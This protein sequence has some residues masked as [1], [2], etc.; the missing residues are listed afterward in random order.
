MKMSKKKVLFLFHE[1]DKNNGANH[2][3]MDI[4][5]FLNTSEEIVPYIAFPKKHGTEVDY[6]KNNN[7]KTYTFRYGRWDYPRKKQTIFYFIK[8]LIK[9]S[10]TFIAFF[11]YSY[12]IRKEK[13]NIVY[14]NTYTVFLGCLL[15][16]FNNI[17]HVWHIREFGEE[18][19]DLKIMFNKNKLYKYM[20]LYSD[21]I[22]FIS[23]SLKQKYIGYITN[24]EKCIVL[25][26]DINCKNNTVFDDNKW[27][28][29]NGYNLLVAG[30]IQAGKCQ[31]D[32]IKACKVLKDKYNIFDYKLYIAGNKKGNYYQ[33][34]K[35]YVTD[36]GLSENIEFTGYIS[37]MDQFRK[38]MLVGIVPS[39]NEAFGRVTVEGMMSSMLVIGA[40]CAGTAELIQ[41]NKTGYLYKLHD[42]EELAK[43]ILKSKDNLKKSM[44]IAKQG[45]NFACNAFGKKQTSKK[46]LDILNKI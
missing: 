32:V 2:S 27:V 12:L 26:N 18:D 42:Y 25:Y 3:M 22:I 20:N 16:R 23:N 10:L 6:A 35:Q 5:D 9:Y 1:T 39:S 33:K 36:N 15:K 43:T 7:Y 44:I 31:L 28:N 38:N 13:I 11:Y 19:H 4:I 8:W 29:S 30:T 34:L 24:K 17:K 14:T 45:Y 37:E 46:I 40:N 41:N 21:K